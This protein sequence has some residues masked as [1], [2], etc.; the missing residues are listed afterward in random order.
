MNPILDL[1]KFLTGESCGKRIFPIKYRIITT[2]MMIHRAIK[3][4]L[5]RKPHCVTRSA[6]E[7]NFIAMAPSRKPRTTLT[8]FSQPPD[9]G[10]ECNQFG[11]I[12]NKVKG[13]AKARP[14][15]ARPAVNGHDPSAAVPAS[16][17]P[18]IGPVHEKETIASVN[19]MKKIPTTSSPEREP[20]LL[21]KPPGSVISK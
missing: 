15:P 13:N 18:R 6:W 4:S 1:E 3:T 7:R 14:N 9:L 20:A 12:A 5:F 16:K 19:A 11:K 8:E 21:A 10:R 2:L 17:E